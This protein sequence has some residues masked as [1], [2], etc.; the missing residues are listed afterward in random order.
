MDAGV[1]AP[2][3]HDFRRCCAIAMYRNGVDI[4]TISKYLGHAGIAITTRYIRLVD[5]DVTE[6]HRRGSPVDR[7]G[8]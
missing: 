4:Y 7:A 8:W 6:A 2:G 5:A 1:K 3:L